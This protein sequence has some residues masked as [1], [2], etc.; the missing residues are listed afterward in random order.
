M[1]GIFLKKEE[2]DNQKEW[3]SLLKNINEMATM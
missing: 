2:K 1:I 3:L